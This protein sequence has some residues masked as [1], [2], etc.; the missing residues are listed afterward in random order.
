MQTH[1][2]TV[3]TEGANLYF[4]TRGQG[5]PLLII[6]G[7]LSEAG[8]TE[9]LAE[10]LAPHYQVIC[11]DRRG[12]SRST[13]SDQEPDITI[14][15]HAD[16]AGVLLAAV[17]Q[18]PAHVVGASIGALIG[19]H[20]AVQHPE[21]VATLVAHEPPMPNLVVDREREA[22]LDKV[23]ALAHDDVIAAIRLMASLTSGGQESAEDG[24]RPAPG[25][26]DLDANLRRF[27]AHDFPAVRASTLSPAQVLAIRD[28]TTVIPAGGAAT[29]G[30]WEYR[31]AQ[32]LAQSIG[33]EFIEMPGGH[34]GMMSHPR[35]TAD[36]LKRLFPEVRI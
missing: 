16:D 31:C 5:A 3:A 12:L 15:R 21:C 9:Q 32:A 2:G 29:R 13:V 19:L 14:A 11:Y 34:N 25:V 6:Q 22:A 1:Q 7:G 36:A 20:L 24:A 23:A 30:G 18:Q 28:S 35:T 26:G 10:F 17:A 8:A 33:R 4:E 27:F